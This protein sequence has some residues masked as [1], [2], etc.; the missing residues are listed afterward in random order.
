MK[1]IFG[2]ISI[3]LLVLMLASCCLIACGGDGADTSTESETETDTEQVV[4]SLVLRGDKTE[5][6]RGE[7]VTLSAL[8]KT[9]ETETV[10]PSG[11]EYKIVEGADYATLSG[12]VLTI[13][14]TA[15]NGD[16]IKLTA[17]V[18]ATTSSELV[19]TVKVP[20]TGLVISADGVTNILAGQSQIIK[21]DITPL[22]AENNVVYTIVEGNTYAEIQGNV[23]V[24]KAAATTGAKIKVQA[25]VGAQASNTL[26]FTVGY[27][28]E[29]L[30]I[31][32]AVTNI[33]EGSTAQVFVTKTP[34][35]ATN[36]DYTITVVEGADY[37]IVMGDTITVKA[38]T[39]TGTKIKV[40]A[41]SGDKESESIEFTVGYP[42]TDIKAELVGSA[43]IEPGKSA[44]INVTVTPSNTTNGSYKFEFT[45]GNEYATFVGD[46]IVIKDNAPIGSVIKFVAKTETK[47]SNE[48][49]VTV[50]T[51]IT[52]ITL[53]TTAPEVLERGETYEFTATVKPE[54]AST[55]A[56]E[57]GISEGAD[58]ATIKDGELKIN[59]NTPAGTT[60]TVY[61]A[62]GSIKDEI[63]F[64]VG[65]VLESIEIDINGLTTGINI[66]PNGSRPISSELF[67]ANASDTLIEWVVSEGKD[68]ATVKDGFITIKENAPIGAIVKFYAKIGDV[69]SE[70]ITVTVGTPITEIVVEAVGSTDVVKG[71]SV[72]L[73]ATV[74]PSS[75]SSALLKWEIVS[76][77][78]YGALKGT[79]LVV[80]A[81]AKTGEKIVVR[82]SFGEVSDEIEI[83]VMATQE[84]ENASKYL[85]GVSNQ[86]FS[87]D[88]F[89]TSS[90]VLS[91]TVLNGNFQS[92]TDLDINFEVIEGAEYLSVNKSGY[93]C[94]FTAL[95]HGTAKVKV[96]IDGYATSEIVTVDV[97]VPP[98]SVNLTGVFNAYPKHEFSFSLVDIRTNKTES[99]PFNVSL[100][101]DGLFCQDLVYT[102]TDENGN[103][104]D[105]V[106][107]YENGKITFNKTGKITLEV[108]S[109]AGSKLNPKA[110]YNFNINR[111]YNVETFEEL[112]FVLERNNGLGNTNSDQYK[113]EP[114]N[115]VVLNEVVDYAGYNYGYALVPS[116]ILEGGEQTIDTLLKG[117]TTYTAENYGV[118]TVTM[119]LQ[120]VNRS[121]HING[122][123]AVIDV[124][125]AKIYTLDDIEQYKKDHNLTDDDMETN[126]NMSSL[127]SVEAWSTNK[128]DPR[129]VGK[130]YFIKLYDLA[131]KGNAPIDYNPA[132]YGK[133]N[134][135]FIGAFES[136]FSLGSIEYGC[137]YAIDVDNLT[138][139]AFKNGLKFSSIVGNG[140]VSNLYAY[141]CY[142][143][144]IVARSSMLTFENLEVGPCGATAIELSENYWNQAGAN[145]NET[146]KII[147]VGK[148]NAETNLNNGSTNYFNNYSIMGATVPQIL[149]AN[150]Q[151]YPTLATSHIVNANG[152]FSLVCLIFNNLETLSPNGTIVEYSSFEQGGGIIDMTDL[153]MSGTTDT[154]H[155][156]IRVK[157]MADIPGIGT[158]Q[159]GTA[160]FYNHNYQ[161]SASVAE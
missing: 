9:G 120:T 123:N 58:Y 15:N 60:I 23:L 1:N 42:L 141:N 106:A 30:D 137:H 116:I 155:Q 132:L 119:R 77:A 114:I 142:S 45:A 134:K 144:G 19:I 110:T 98:T 156:F 27:P 70:P 145:D 56:I 122:N 76:G 34:S 69:T 97:I 139:S 7:A 49:T 41:V 63:T 88:K 115:I 129:V 6:Q 138:A 25:T 21:A 101:G 158:Q 67:P 32:S 135:D 46:T 12:N 147:F 118:R 140:R 90:P 92:V 75:A 62:S 105:S 86:Y 104:G 24:V 160:I 5:A 128:E 109:A 73:M 84:E 47:T 14:N 20:A 100:K 113:G 37:V 131:V 74:T 117:Y 112:D 8:I 91:A 149:G 96:S 2:K 40:K 136:G 53:S 64:T 61:A 72:T 36:G 95:G 17:L 79:S 148:V 29:S 152:Q 31:Q 38:G 82:A 43:N 78:E 157:I 127:L 44:V 153:A 154:E 108:S 143:T 99:L 18:G 80:N 133:D 13:K 55:S 39:P 89:G 57:W 94:R 130:D 50:G 35:N 87:I 83:T 59:K 22:G 54:G 124:S 150:M 93:D 51:P 71:N 3:F 48:I 121:L 68:Y 4:S 159:V 103:T 66:D 33:L 81:D 102:F 125:K 161:A 107:V 10:I 28:L 85:L 16:T 26:E 126:L 65:V 11:V 151:A 146:A 52:E 111:G